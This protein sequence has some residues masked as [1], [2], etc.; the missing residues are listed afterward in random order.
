LQEGADLL[1]VL[2]RQ[3]LSICQSLAF[4]TKAIFRSFSFPQTRV[5]LLVSVL[6]VLLNAC[7]T[8]APGIGAQQDV[9]RLEQRRDV[10]ALVDLADS[11]NKRT[12]L[13]AIESLG[14]LRDPRAIAVLTEALASDS[15][16]EREAAAKAIGKMKDYLAVKPL[17]S[18]LND[19]DKFVRETALKGL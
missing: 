11:G 5:F 2:V 14:N 4:A 1:E 9:K 6:L 7:G 13:M 15:W 16:V 18:V 10:E 17:L 8:T 3:Q 19:E 12:R